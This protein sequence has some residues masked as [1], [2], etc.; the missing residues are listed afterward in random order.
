MSSATKPIPD[1]VL[2]TF[3]DAGLTHLMSFYKGLAEDSED[4]DVV[5]YI[6]TRIEDIYRVMGY[7]CALQYLNKYDN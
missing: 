1:D 6:N 3:P 2:H 7:R 5:A 4:P